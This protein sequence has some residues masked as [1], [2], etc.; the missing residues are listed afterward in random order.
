LDIPNFPISIDDAL[1]LDGSRQWK[2]EKGCYVVSTFNNLNLATQSNNYTQPKLNF[3]AD[4]APESGFVGVPFANGIGG[5][6]FS[7]PQKVYW[8]NFNCSG[9]IFTGLDPANAMSIT[10]NVAIERFPNSTNKNLSVLASKSPILDNKALEIYSEIMTDMPVGVTAA[11]NGFGD[12][13]AQAAS[14]VAKVIMPIAR[15][16]PHPGVQAAV[17]AHDIFTQ[18]AGSSVSNPAH[19][20]QPQKAVKTMVTKAKNLQI[21]A[22]NEIIKAKNAEIRAKKALKKK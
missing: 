6:G 3:A 15:L 21:R 20:Y 2:A 7:G 9:A 4:G 13:F 19:V 16:T 11:E 22:K 12:W 17:M 1:K 10:Y 8:T 14:N 5:A 18:P